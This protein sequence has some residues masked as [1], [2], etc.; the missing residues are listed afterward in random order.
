M[1]DGENDSRFFQKTCKSTYGSNTIRA[2]PILNGNYVPIV[3]VRPIRNKIS[4]N[5]SIVESNINNIPK[6]RNVMPFIIK[7][8]ESKATEVDVEP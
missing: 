4:P 8:Q 1:S 5:A 2:A 7:N 3:N 6:N